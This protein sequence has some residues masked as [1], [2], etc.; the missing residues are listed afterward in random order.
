MAIL[1][2]QFQVCLA[3]HVEDPPWALLIQYGENKVA[4]VAAFVAAFVVVGT[5]LIVTDC[6]LFMQLS[7][8]ATVTSSDQTT[9]PFVW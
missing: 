5:D 6:F 9:Q 2:Y 3:E 4:F 1:K 8:I 7:W